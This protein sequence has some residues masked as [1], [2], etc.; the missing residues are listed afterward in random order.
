M[1]RRRKVDLFEEIRHE[2]RFGSG[3]IQGVAKK[4]KTNRRMMRQALASAIPYSP[5]GNPIGSHKRG[6]WKLA[7]QD[8]G[9]PRRARM[10]VER[11]AVSH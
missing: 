9:N 6:H 11:G 3:T 2:Y 7:P 5:H 8:S 4:L 10:R 1:N